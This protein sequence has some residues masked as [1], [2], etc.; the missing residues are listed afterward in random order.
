MFNRL[1]AASRPVIVGSKFAWLLLALPLC[2]FAAQEK[3][4]PFT[5]T[6]AAFE[7]RL[8]VLEE[9]K[10]DAA[11]ANEELAA[12]KANQERLRLRSGRLP[13]SPEGFVSP[14]RVPPARATPTPVAV[15]PAPAI[16]SRPPRLVGTVSTTS[17]WVALVESGDK[18]L[19]VP[20]GQMVSGL[21][22]SGISRDRATINGV[23]MALDSVTARVA[24][25]ALPAAIHPARAG[26]SIPGTGV[27][28]DVID[29]GPGSTRK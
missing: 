8:R 19:N 6:T 11:I 5:G 7:Q 29:L 27:P 28:A 14:L 17:G 18:V 25:P 1:S 4:N 15:P 2:V 12:E 3:A 9:K 26:T 20:E 16:K 21:K 24:G 13:G 10:L 22:A 23:A